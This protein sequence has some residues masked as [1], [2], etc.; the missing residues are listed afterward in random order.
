[1]LSP[2][3][4]LSKPR[5]LTNKTIIPGDSMKS[6]AGCALD[7]GLDKSVFTAAGS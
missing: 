2:A 1:L 5:M 7:S 4:N 3:R 6:N